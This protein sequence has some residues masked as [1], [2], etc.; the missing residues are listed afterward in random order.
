MVHKE[1]GIMQCDKHDSIPGRECFRC[2]PKKY[3]PDGHLLHRNT[4]NH[5]WGCVGNVRF[6]L[7]DSDEVAL[8]EARVMELC[9]GCKDE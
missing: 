8:H 6:M 7:L 1:G 2:D 3:V 9:S 5:K 4:D